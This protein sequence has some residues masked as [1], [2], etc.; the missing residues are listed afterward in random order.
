MIAQI[1]GLR[2]RTYQRVAHPMFSGN[3]NTP[4][5][6]EQA[7]R[8]MPMLDYFSCEINSDDILDVYIAAQ[9]LAAHGKPLVASSQATSNNTL[10]IQRSVAA[11]FAASFLS[12]SGATASSAAAADF[13]PDEGGLGAIKPTDAARPAGP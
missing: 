1:A 10:V 13:F 7:E 12:K 9:M 4:H 8:L 3:L 5:P 2:S 6:G 11:G